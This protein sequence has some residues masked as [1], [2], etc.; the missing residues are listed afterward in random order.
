MTHSEPAPLENPRIFDLTA[1]GVTVRVVIGGRG[2]DEFA[3]RILTTWARCDIHEITGQVSDTAYDGAL[4]RGVLDPD[5]AVHEI[6]WN[7]NALAGETL[8]IVETLLTSAVTMTAITA[9][10]GELLMIHAAGLAD[11]RTGRTAMLIGSSGAG[12]TTLCRTLGTQLAY[13]SDE[14]IA[15]DSQDS[16]IGYPKPLALVPTGGHGAKTQ[17]SPD[18]LELVSAPS[19][20]KLGAVV[21]LSRADDGPNEPEIRE[22]PAAEALALVAE[23][24]S[25]LS[26]LA[27]PLNHLARVVFSVGPVLEIRYREAET[28]AATLTELLT[29]PPPAPLRSQPPL[30]SLADLDYDQEPF[31][32]EI[33]RAELRDFYV[34]AEGAVALT[35]DGRTIALSALAA[36]VMTLVAKT[37][38]TLPPIAAALTDE[39]GAPPVDFDHP[40]LRLTDDVVSDLVANGLVYHLDEVSQ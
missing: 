20:L 10:R 15:F 13:V 40:A 30:P 32:R 21:I 22:L 2:R 23:N 19:D 12:K 17:H 35:L 3:E 29:T 16:I 24:T 28:L 26:E 8:E 36:R 38:T 27:Q 34:T 33:A 9:A 14:T 5:P 37:T 1:F 4:V 6:A 7:Q 11:P 31:G 18:A 25:F 39:F